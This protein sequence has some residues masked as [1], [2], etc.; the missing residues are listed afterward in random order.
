MRSQEL[1]FHILSIQAYSPSRKE[2]FCSKPRIRP[3]PGNA[4][5]APGSGCKAAADADRTT[6]G[7]GSACD[8]YARGLVHVPQAS[9]HVFQTSVDVSQAS[10]HVFQSPF[11][12]EG[13]KVD[14]HNCWGEVDNP[15]LN[16]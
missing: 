6:G 13:C 5:R 14:V 7:M 10:G 11:L 9:V 2:I 3:A 8:D 15:P 12:K 4:D 16:L 1:T